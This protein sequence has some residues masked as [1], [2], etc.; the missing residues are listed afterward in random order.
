MI[1]LKR[2]RSPKL[3]RLIQV[4]PSG[5][6]TVL[7]SNKPWPELEKLKK[8][9]ISRGYSEKS[10]KVTYLSERQNGLNTIG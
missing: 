10:L 3:G 2:E 4:F 1:K 5:K 6:F 7:A 9:Y 8:K